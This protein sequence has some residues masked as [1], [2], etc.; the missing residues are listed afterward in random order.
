MSK[1]RKPELS[2]TQLAASGLATA[3][4]AVGTSY[5][6]VAGTLIGA[7]LTSVATTAG[8][9]IYQHYLDRGKTR[10]VTLVRNERDEHSAGTE[11][12]ERAEHSAQPDGAETAVLR[13]D[14]AAGTVKRL[15]NGAEATELLGP[16][17]TPTMIIDS[18]AE[19]RLDLPPSDGE[20]DRPAATSSWLRPRWYVLAGAAVAIFAVVMGGITLVEALANKPVSS[21]VGGPDRS[22]TSF[23]QT[24]G[25]GGSTPANEPSTSPTATPTTSPSGSV[26]PTP[27][28]N[29]TR[30]GGPQP[31]Q[32]SAPP[33][34]PSSPTPAPTTGK[35]TGKSS[36]GA[37]PAS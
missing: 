26:Q 15:V 29:P 37:A 4:A 28:A 2:A 20:A 31:P 13:V 25:G 23:G 1:R 12:S 5:L 14:P 7:A 11:H 17:A 30:P 16:L 32:S 9:T 34:G 21:M 35:T 6:G 36:P 33:T 27:S 3:T 24:F 8:A 18:A 22:G 10:Y 19:T